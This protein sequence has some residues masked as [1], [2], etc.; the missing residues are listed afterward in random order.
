MTS[1]PPIDRRTAITW[2]FT[3]AAATAL[4]PNFAFG[5]EWT[6]AKNGYGTDPDLSKAYRPGELWPLTFTAAQRRAAA[7]LC[8]A[9][10]PADAE[11]PAASTVGVVDFLDEWVSA[12]YPDQ[13][14]DRG[15]V[16]PGLAWIDAEAQRRFSR[17]FA[18]LEDAQRAAIC[19]EICNV[20]RARPEHQEAARFFARYRDLTA[21]AFY[22]TPE[23]VKDLRYVGNVA[24]ASYDGPPPEVRRRAGLA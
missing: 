7:A 21:G 20:P 16:L 13:V 9:I 15:V 10:I 4:A 12:P 17:D 14:A 11:S 19:D 8:D 18:S 2:I 24:L 23:G 5:K 22:T 6:A 3:A 1:L